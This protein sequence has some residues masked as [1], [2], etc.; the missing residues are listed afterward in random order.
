MRVPQ[1][2]R[3]DG[4][5]RI[6]QALRTNPTQSLDDIAFNV[7]YSRTSVHAIIKELEISQLLTK[8]RGRGR[9]PNNYK[10]VD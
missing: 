3:R 5:R 10:V 1:I 9:T 2:H 6:L 4:A 8:K 7:A